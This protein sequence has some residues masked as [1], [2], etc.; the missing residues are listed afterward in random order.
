[1]E[2]DARIKGLLKIFDSEVGGAEPPTWDPKGEVPSRI[3]EWHDLIAEK[4]ITGELVV[5]ASMLVG[6]G[7]LNLWDF[8][9]T[10]WLAGPLSVFL[11]ASLLAPL[12][13][14]W[15]KSWRILLLVAGLGNLLVALFL[16]VAEWQLQGLPDDP[17]RA[18]VALQWR[19]ENLTSPASLSINGLVLLLLRWVSS[20]LRERRP[21]ITRRNR[22]PRWRYVGMVAVLLVP[23]MAAVYLLIPPLRVAWEARSGWIQQTPKPVYLPLR[24]QDTALLA[25]VRSDPTD[26]AAVA[27]LEARARLLTKALIDE[28]LDGAG[29][30]LTERILFLASQVEV[31]SQAFAELAIANLEHFAQL[32]PDLFPEFLGHD[33]AYVLAR[34]LAAAPLGLKQLQ[35]W[36]ERLPEQLPVLTPR[37]HARRQDMRLVNRFYGMK[38][39]GSSLVGESLPGPFCL[40]GVEVS[41]YSLVD[42]W[43]N[44]ERTAV[45]DAYSRFRKRRGNEQTLPFDEGWVPGLLRRHSKARLDHAFSYDT[46]HL[47]PVD[48]REPRAIL[49]ARI[50]KAQTGSYPESLNN[51]NVNYRKIGEKAEVSRRWRLP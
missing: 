1:M 27:K 29:L 21:W 3:I 51:S 33:E 47:R 20:K 28:S 45:L 34:Y 12:V 23:I 50:I 2:E 42:L 46:A 49:R 13:S 48:F 30:T 8:N 26:L 39:C 22:L 10:A 16:A 14:S 41:D 18:F 25:A 43:Y 36:Q 5:L 17:L 24:P 9:S 4:L 15:G 19:V 44:W 7:S 31:P 38:K 37:E 6:L 32:E 40:F 35:E 11:I